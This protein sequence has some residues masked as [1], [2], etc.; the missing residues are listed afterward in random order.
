MKIAMTIAAI[1]VFSVSANAQKMMTWKEIYRINCKAVVQIY[2]G[3]TFRGTGFIVSS[4]GVILTANHVVTTRESRLRQYASDIKVLVNGNDTPYPAIPLPAEV[5]DDQVNYDSALVKITATDLPHV[6]LGDWSKIDI[7]D[8][9]VMISSFPGMG[10]I[11]L[12]GMVSSKA[13]FLTPLGPKPV[14]TL[15]FQCPVRNGFSGAPIFDSLGRVVAI[16]D[17]KVFGI[18]P[19]LDEL[20]SK[21][22]DSP[23]R[24][25][26]NRIDIGSTNVEL[27]N[28]LDQN[29]I[30]DL[31][32]GIDVSYAKREQ[33][34]EKK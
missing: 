12:Q 34:S 16:V 27:I 13:A 1:W 3:D 20:R 14:N 29:L 24:V 10:C 11:M 15:L 6:A 8:P 26:F 31:G 2:V 25:L 5:S 19:A 17:T 21:W 28:N 7:G 4:D 9:L 18:A 30:S 23:V 32:S 22:F 33:E